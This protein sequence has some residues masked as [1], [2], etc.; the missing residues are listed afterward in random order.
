[1]TEDQ[2]P[3]EPAPAPPTPEPEPA[4]PSPLT[5]RVFPAGVNPA[6]TWFAVGIVVLVLVIVGISYRNP[7]MLVMT[8]LVFAVALNGY[9]LPTT[10]TFDAGGVTTDKGFFRFTRR[11]GEFRS[12]VRTTSGVVISPFRDWTYLDNFRGIHL[13]LPRD[14]TQI[15]EYLANRLPEKRRPPRRSRR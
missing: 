15:L 1:M 4:E 3:I 7:F 9:F 2:N 14:P 11:W 13:L 6:K 8:I 5:W 10:Y 12:F